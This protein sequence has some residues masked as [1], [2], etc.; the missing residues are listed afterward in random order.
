MAGSVNRL[1]RAEVNELVAKANCKRLIPPEPTGKEP[2]KYQCL[3]CGEK[4]QRH[5]TAQ[6]HHGP[7]SRRLSAAAASRRAA[8]GHD[9]AG[10]DSRPAA[11]PT[12]ATADDDRSGRHDGAGPSGR[13]PSPPAMGGPPDEPAHSDDLFDVRTFGS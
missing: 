10:P 5:N 2:F 9:D 6:N 12:S 11:G 4:F 7:C 8:G 1:K 13:S 3:A